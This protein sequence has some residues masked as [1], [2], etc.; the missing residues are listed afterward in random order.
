M[1]Y[2][3][4]VKVNICKNHWGLVWSSEECPAISR[5]PDWRNLRLLRVGTG[6]ASIKQRY[7][8]MWFLSWMFC[9]WCWKSKCE[10][11]CLCCHWWAQPV[12]F[13][14]GLGPPSRRASSWGLTCFLMHLF[15]W[16]WSVGEKMGEISIWDSVWYLAQEGRIFCISVVQ[17]VPDR[18]EPKV[19]FL[20]LLSNPLQIFMMCWV[21]EPCWISS[22]DKPR[23]PRV[24]LRLLLLLQRGFLLFLA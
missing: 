16:E 9:E 18:P 8:R 22:S 23:C 15:R 11:C 2:M 6:C 3:P 21:I 24:C 17:Y 7:L 13:M 14:T 10:L 1:F 12:A 5:V 19:P 4:C 20:L